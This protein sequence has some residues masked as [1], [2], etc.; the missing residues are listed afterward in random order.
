MND[1]DKKILNSIKKQLIDFINSEHLSDWMYDYAY[2]VVSK[3]I[4]E[5]CEVKDVLKKE[6]IKYMMGNAADVIH[7]EMSDHDIPAFV[8]EKMIPVINDF[9]EAALDQK[10]S[11]IL[12]KV[13]ESFAN[14]NIQEM[15]EAQAKDLVSKSMVDLLT[16]KNKKAPKKKVVSKK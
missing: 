9:I 12:R 15:V 13:E 8:R 4:S 16:S 14:L 1:F 3:V 6:G 10:Q 2:E 7:N 5:S 11:E